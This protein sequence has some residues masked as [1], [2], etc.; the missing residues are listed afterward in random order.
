MSGKGS[1]RGD[2]WERPEDGDEDGP[3]IEVPRRQAAPRGLSSRARCGG[4]SAGRGPCRHLPGLPAEAG[5]ARRDCRGAPGPG[6]SSPGRHRSRGGNGP[7]EDG[8]GRGPEASWARSFAPRPPGSSA[9]GPWPPRASS[10]RRWPPA[11]S[12]SRS[13]GLGMPTG[14]TGATSGSSNRPRLWTGLP[15]TSAG[16][17][18]R[19]RTSIDSRSSTRS[20][21]RSSCAIPRARP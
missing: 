5:R 19:T 12:F 17:P 9:F 7:P 20:S 10:S 6:R 14:A 15:L 3:T 16:P 11:S 8:P 4:E 2:P 18:F 21:S 1:R 13:P